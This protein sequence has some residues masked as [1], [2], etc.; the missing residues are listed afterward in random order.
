MCELH[1]VRAFR[2]QGLKH[3]YPRSR[4]NRRNRKQK[5]RRR[6]STRTSKVDELLARAMSETEDSRRPPGDGLVPTLHEK[7]AS[8]TTLANKFCILLKVGEGES[9]RKAQLNK[10]NERRNEESETKEKTSAKRVSG[11][12]RS[13]RDSTARGRTERRPSQADV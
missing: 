11:G 1:H 9:T 6:L 7:G 4:G 8:Q 3:L 2:S 10:T 13:G 12:S 5:V